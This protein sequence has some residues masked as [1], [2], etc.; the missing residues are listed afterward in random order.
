MTSQPAANSDT[1]NLA[2]GQEL[3]LK[4]P[5]AAADLFRLLRLYDGEGDLDRLF[6]RIDFSRTSPAELCHL[7]L[8]RPLRPAEVASLHDAYDPAQFALK[9][10]TSREFQSDV[11]RLLLLAFPEKRRLFFVHI[12]KCAG[13]D[14]ETHLTPRYLSIAHSMTSSAW[15]STARLFGFLSGFATMVEFVSDV[16]IYGHLPFNAY[17]RRIGVRPV[18]DVFTVLRD[19]IEIMISQA[20]YHIGLLVKDPHHRRPDTRHV[21]EG[22]Q[23]ESLPD[24]IP[25]TLLRKLAL[26]ALTNPQMV[27]AD[28]IC[29]HL[30]NGKA[31][32]TLENLISYDVEVTDTAR[33][34]RWLKERWAI[35]SNTRHNRSLSILQRSDVEEHIDFLRAQTEQ[36]RIL[37]DTIRRTLDKSGLS[38][39]RGSALA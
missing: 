11:I 18:D 10:L 31:D 16:L 14:L 23:V 27:R 30:G 5:G 38:S 8:G 32:L 20:N 33:Y 29:S 34:Q 24:P 12:P 28:R 22:L 26:R 6:A 25:P 15:N 13:T 35:D 19:P 1:G 4:A 17:A 21:M 37:F 9:L 36:D 2:D 7:I 3:I 39:L